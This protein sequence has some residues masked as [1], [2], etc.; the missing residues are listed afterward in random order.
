[1]RLFLRIYPW[2]LAAIGFSLLVLGAVT[3]PSWSFAAGYAMIVVLAATVGARITQIPLTKYSAL[4]MVGPVAVAGALVAGAPAS[5]FGTYIG[6]LIADHYLLGKPLEVGA[7]N[8]GREVTALVVAYGFFAWLAN[9]QDVAPIAAQLSQETVPAF[10]VLVCMHFIV[11]RGLLYLTLILRDKLLAG[12]KSLILRYEVISFG[13]GT[14]AIAISIG[15][16]PHVHWQAMF[17]VTIALAFSGLLMRRI[18]EESI[19]AEELNKILAMEQVISSDSDIATAFRRIERL[20]NRL[21]DWTSLR[22]A[23]MTPDG[24]V[25]IYKSKLGYLAVP[26]PPPTHAAQLRRMAVDSGDA[27]TV[28]DAPRDPRVLSVP[29]NVRSMAIMPLRF[30]D[31]V[32]GLLELEHHKANIYRAKERDLIARFATQLAT[33]LHIHDLRQPLLEAVTRLGTQLETLNGSART[34]RAGGEAVARTMVDIVRGLTEESDQAAYSLDATHQMHEAAQTVVRDGTFAAE[35]T[36]RASNLAREHCE[37]IAAAIE[38]LVAAK[39]FVAESAAEVATLSDATVRM[40]AFIADI[41]ELADQTNLLALNAA[42]EAARA[43]EQGQGFAVVAAEVRSLAD[44]SKHT[45]EQVSDLLEALDSQSHRMGAQMAHGQGMMADVESLAEAALLALGG[46]VDATASGA[47]GVQRIAETS[48]DTEAQIIQLR[49]RVARIAEISARNRGSADQVSQSARDQA[50]A[51]RGLE[52]AAQEL[53][54]VAGNLDNLARRIAQ[55][56]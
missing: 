41:R 56:G 49:E 8:A 39:G 15:T 19:A 14:G 1:V 47:E 3:A 31:R 55:V 34:L 13:A 11:G 26:E 44:E 6:I 21:M 16:I 40:S 32:I 29:P 9:L 43:G 20:A 46:I 30:G 33:A 45:A 18:L 27:L 42:I 36:G 23:R 54:G 53:R 51:L 38:R 5:A 10:A 25:I 17:A 4:S 2:S 37:T 48:R 7:V 50:L 52:G 24:P 35:S 22:I 12:E 28:L